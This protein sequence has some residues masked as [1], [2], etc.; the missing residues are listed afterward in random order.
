MMKA[1]SEVKQLTEAEKLQERIKRY[2]EQ[3]AEIKAKAA[4][5]KARVSEEKRK[6]ETQQKIILGAAVQSYLAKANASDGDT[7]RAILVKHL[8]VADAKK[9]GLIDDPVDPFDT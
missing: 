5:L 6:K 7:M 9:V 4:R 1:K 3:A 2:D 8:T